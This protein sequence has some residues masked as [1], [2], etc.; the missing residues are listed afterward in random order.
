M[1]EELSVSFTAIF[2]LL[3][4]IASTWSKL[5]LILPLTMEYMFLVFP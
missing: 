3:I 4:K 1:K 2:V 5:S